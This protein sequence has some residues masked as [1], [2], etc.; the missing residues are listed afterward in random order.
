MLYVKPHLTVI[1]AREG[2]EDGHL[3]GRVP[4]PPLERIITSTDVLAADREGTRLLGHEA[5]SIDHLKLAEEFR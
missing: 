4:N 3:S 5:E 1:D 2:L